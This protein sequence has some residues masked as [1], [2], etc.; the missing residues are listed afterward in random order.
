MMQPLPPEGLPA[1]RG[2]PDPGEWLSR[3]GDALYRYALARLRRP[4]EAEEAVQETLLAA[5]RA[6]RQFRGQSHPRTWLIGILKRKVLDLARAAARAAPADPDDL[7][8]W[9]N[10]RGKWRRP[11]GRWPGPAEV[12]ERSELWAVVRRCLGKLPARTAAAFTLRVL[13]EAAPDE[14]CRALAISPANLWVLLHRARLG[15]VRCL[16]TNWFDAEG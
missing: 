2:L 8:E 15:L 5:L 4:H 14:V 12:A 13:D 1:S 3:Y 10:A 6:R 11:P 16:Q 7:G 9:F